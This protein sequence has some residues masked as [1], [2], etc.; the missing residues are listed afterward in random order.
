M[1]WHHALHS[2][3]AGSVQHMS[4]QVGLHV[5]PYERFRLTGQLHALGQWLANHGQGGTMSN[6]PSGEP[7]NDMLVSLVPGLGPRVSL[8]WSDRYAGW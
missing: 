4:C 5:Q 8:L 1:R 7:Y 3:D 6:F 2:V